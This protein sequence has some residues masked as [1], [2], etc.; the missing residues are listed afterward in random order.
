MSEFLDSLPKVELHVHVEG[1]V[2]PETALRLFRRYGAAEYDSEPAVRRLF[3][4][5]SFA[6]FLAHYRCLCR[7]F[8]A[9]EDL[10]LLAAE[11]VEDQ[12][13][14]RILYTE[15]IL[16]PGAVR[17]LCG[18]PA[19]EGLEAVLRGIAAGER[20]CGVRVVLLLDLVRNLGLEEGW[21][22][23]ELALS[24]MGQ[25]VVGITLGGDETRFPAAPYAELYQWARGWGL[26]TTAHAGE[27]AGPGSVWDCTQKLGVERIGHGVRAI[28]DAALL[29]YLAEHKVPL[30]CCPTS[31]VATGVVSD[32]PSHPVRALYDRHIPLSVSTDD[33]TLFGT[34][35][36]RELQGLMDHHDFTAGEVG[37]IVRSAIDQSFLDP[38]GREGLHRQLD[39]YLA[40]RR[41]AEEE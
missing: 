19:R 18:I 9:P 14:Q 10:E 36:S 25:G 37:G 4:H 2:R 8:R 15:A 35:L 21:R 20:A 7:A 3:T 39:E 11:F 24:R 13:A 22:I 17:A 27:G 31:N 1:A 40:S 41:T 23:A 6:S 16:S 38:A 26:H 32:W 33:P 30:E 5:D 29:E 28:E 12:A 34:T